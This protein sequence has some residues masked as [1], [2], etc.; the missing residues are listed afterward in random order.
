MSSPKN[1]KGPATGGRHRVP[2]PTSHRAS[3]HPSRVW[4]LVTA[5][6]P[7]WT[8]T[9]GKHIAAFGRAGERTSALRA[10]MPQQRR[11]EQT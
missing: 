10:L 4:P 8:Q 6:Q 5:P 2:T 1:A 7:W 9:H 11:G 3:D